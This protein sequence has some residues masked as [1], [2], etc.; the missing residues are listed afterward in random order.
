LF[1]GDVDWFFLALVSE[2][3]VSRWVCS[4]S[5]MT[6]A[7][8]NMIDSSVSF[9][10]ILSLMRRHNHEIL[11]NLHSKCIFNQCKCLSTNA[12]H[13]D[14]NVSLSFHL[15]W[16]HSSSLKSL[17]WFKNDV[18]SVINWIVITHRACVKDNLVVQVKQMSL[19]FSNLIGL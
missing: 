19:H 4:D 16:I 17:L 12:W 15:L 11:H 7:M 5:Q 10:Y 2:F 13:L 18:T 1:W 9:I 8:D 3:R 14:S 6:C